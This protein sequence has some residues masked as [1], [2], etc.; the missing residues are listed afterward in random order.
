MTVCMGPE[1]ASHSFYEILAVILEALL[2]AVEDGQDILTLSLGEVDGWTESSSSVVASRIAAS[3]KVVTVAAGNDVRR[4]S[5]LYFD[6][7]DTFDKG[8]SGSWYS[9]SPGNGINVISV[10]SLDRWVLGNIHL[11]S[12]LI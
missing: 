5:Y 12:L 6:V 4:S 7:A 2:L 9:S 10:S 1:A 8:A 11:G 3:G